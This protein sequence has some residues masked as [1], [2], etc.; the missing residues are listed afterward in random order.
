M[1]LED[2]L[3]KRFWL[4]SNLDVILKEVEFYRDFKELFRLPRFKLWSRGEEEGKLE[5][6]EITRRPNKVQQS[7]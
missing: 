4:L 7:V 6:D 2:R 1:D 5:L 3:N